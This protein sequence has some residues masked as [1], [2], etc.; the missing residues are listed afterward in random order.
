[1]GTLNL[2]GLGKK[3]DGLTDSE[4]AEVAAK[5]LAAKRASNRV[6]MRK[7]R[8][9]AKKQKLM[10]EIVRMQAAPEAMIG[11]ARDEKRTAEGSAAE[12]RK[13]ANASLFFLC[14]YV[15]GWVDGGRGP[16]PVWMEEG[17]HRPWCDWLD[18]ET[19]KPWELLLEPRGHGKSSIATVGK[20][21][22]RHL[23]DPNLSLGICSY[24][25]GLAEK[26]LW[27]IADH[28]QRNET[29]R[30]IA[31][32][33]IWEDCAK[34][35]PK[36]TTSEILL[37]RNLIYRVPSV[38]AF[39]LEKEVTGYHYDEIY[40]DDCVVKDNSGTE[41][42]LNKTAD[43]ISRLLSLRK[44]T[45]HIRRVRLRG[46]RWH[47]EDAYGRMLDPKGPF[48]GKV[49]SMVGDVIDA[50]TGQPIW[51]SRFVIE[52]T[53]P[54]NDPRECLKT[55]EGMLKDE[56][57]AY[58]RNSPIAG[59]VDWFDVKKVSRFDLKV[60]G[61]GRWVH[62]EDKVYNL[63]IAVDPNANQR[64]TSDPCVVLTAA[65]DEDDR[66]WVVDMFRGKP[67]PSELPGIVRAAYARWTPN[68]VFVESIAYQATI[69]HW[70]QREAIQTG[71]FMRITELKRSGGP[72]K[73]RRIKG[74]T[75]P[76]SGGRIAVANGSHLDQV[77]TEMQMF[78]GEGSKNDDI[79]DCMAD[80]YNAGYRPPRTERRPPPEAPKSQWVVKSYFENLTKPQD[81][82]YHPVVA[83]RP[84]GYYG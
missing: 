55:L 70:L 51:P 83:S 21:I 72:A 5:R 45:S 33:L 50:A 60:N 73:L 37:N 49:E 68:T 31:P 38:V 52:N 32:E 69:V 44:P 42:Q 2:L 66:L 64:E 36:W 20:C 8:R 58:Y 81:N 43:A 16:G 78:V 26:F 71:T 39:S 59:G 4:R 54:E 12:N 30:W 74:L 41:D 6:T 14:K 9:E 75:G 46:T 11:P 67:S 80:V 77:L 34:D 84:I 35:S 76:C 18:R 24:K 10:A 56:F 47:Y 82:G 57:W 53:D 17:L 22:Q 61:N 28:W 7:I 1:M 19:V 65:L 25:A 63:F 15:F 40:G 62:P 13:Q 79:L 27:D 23:Q 3:S 48:K 29:L